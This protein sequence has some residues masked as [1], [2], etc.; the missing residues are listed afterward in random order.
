MNN[1]LLF[2][3]FFFLFGLQFAVS[4]DFILKGGVDYASYP[5]TSESSV[6]SVFTPEFLPV[7]GA[8]LKGDFAGMYNYNISCGSDPIWRNTASGDI[9]C[10]FG[11]VNMSIGFFTGTDDFTFKY[12]DIGFSGRAGIEFPGAFLVKAGFASSVNYDTKAA[13]TSWRQMID[14]QA[15]FWLPHILII[16][17]LQMK[18]YTKQVTETLDIHTSRVRYTGSMDIFAKNMPYRIC[19]SFGYQVLSRI[20]TESVPLEESNY[21]SF[22]AGFRFYFQAGKTFAW[23]IEGEAPFT[24]AGSFK[25]FYNAS[26]GLVFSYPES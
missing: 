26:L 16:A 1:K 6:G 4:W 23:F 12:T 8:T 22:L 19:F 20:M 7:A 24:I 15:G 5:P 14:A 17:E 21:E 9:G 3:L 25:F 10:Y 13:G 11:N 2:V 18:D